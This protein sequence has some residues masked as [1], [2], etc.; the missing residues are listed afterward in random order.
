MPAETRLRPSGP[1][2]PVSPCWPCLGGRAPTKSVDY[3]R[4]GCRPSR[5]R[6]SG[7]AAAERVARREGDLT[8]CSRRSPSAGRAGYYVVP[9]A[10]A[11]GDL[12]PERPD[13]RRRRAPGVP[14]KLREIDGADAALYVTVSD[15]G[16]ALHGDQQTRSIVTASAKLVD[17]RS[18]TTPWTGFLRTPPARKATAA[19]T[20]ASGMLITAA[21]T[22]H[23]QFGG[24]RR[25][26]DR[27][28]DQRAP[29]CSA[30]PA[31][32][33]V[34][35][36]APAE[37]RWQ[38][39][40]CAPGL[41]GRLRGLLGAS[42]REGRAAALRLAMYWRIRSSSNA[43]MAR[44]SGSAAGGRMV[45]NCRRR[46]SGSVVVAALADQPVEGHRETPAMVCSTTSDGCPPLVSK[47]RNWFHGDAQS[48]GHLPLGQ[49]VLLAVGVG[50]SAR[51]SWKTL[52]VRGEILLPPPR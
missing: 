9:V 27:R 4:S 21:V 51:S 47:C 40:S 2:G 25:L 23:Q 3:R 38:R 20:A 13:Q 18:G 49:G 52:Q 1:G 46:S 5:A 31:G 48:L 17:L 26:S 7:P 35:R 50:D 16:I 8:A 12:P 6:S 30:G 28:D 45:S 33:T 14:A 24:G 32:R 44:R 15:Y 34:V 11:D 29:S 43:R 39:L 37:V 42:R 22:D 10:L 19:T 36:P 41:R